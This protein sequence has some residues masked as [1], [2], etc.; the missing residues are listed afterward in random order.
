MFD[1]FPSYLVNGNDLF[2]VKV[3]VSV[4]ALVR[5]PKTPSDARVNVSVVQNRQEHLIVLILQ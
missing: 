3:I 4:P 1:A 5:I 2:V